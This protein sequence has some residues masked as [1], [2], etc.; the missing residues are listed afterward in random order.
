MLSELK[1]ELGLTASASRQVVRQRYLDLCKQ[2]HP[3]KTTDSDK[4][5]RY[6]RIKEV[7]AEL[8]ARMPVDTKHVKSRKPQRVQKQE[9]VYKVDKIMESEEEKREKEMMRV[10]LGVSAMMALFG[11]FYCFKSHR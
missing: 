8:M 7:Y 11:I 3:D 1:R 5:R 2:L 9:E 6:V 10:R 4:H